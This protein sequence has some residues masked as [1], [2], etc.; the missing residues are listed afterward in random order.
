MF[1]WLSS[2]ITNFSRPS[3]HFQTNSQIFWLFEIK[4]SYKTSLEFKASSRTNYNW[5]FRIKIHLWSRH[6]FQ[7]SLFRQQ[8]N[9]KKYV[10]GKGR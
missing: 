5:Y 1:D 9:C 6:Y 7:L 10:M 2:Y 3:S 8:E 4:G